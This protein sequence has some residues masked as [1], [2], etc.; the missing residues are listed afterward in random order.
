M[1][2]SAALL[3][4]VAQPPQAPR[5]LVST[6]WL[7][8]NLERAGLVIIQIENQPQRFDEGHI[9]GARF[10]HANAIAVPGE[11]EVGVEMPPVDSIVRLLERAG[12]GDD[13]HIV[14]ASHG[15]LNAAR[16]W[17]TLDWIGHGDHASLLDGGMQ[18]WRA[19]DRPLRSG[20][21]R[22]DAAAGR[23]TARPRANML[24]DADWIRTR[25]DD[26]GI[27]LV[28]ARPDDEYTGADGGM[29]GMTRAGHIPGAHQLYFERLL[30][31]R[32][33][34]VLRPESELRA[35]MAEAGADGTRTVVAYCM[36]GVRASLTYFTARM[37]G[38]D[39][40]FYDGS[41]H[42]WG[43]RDLP[44]VMGNRPR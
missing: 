14:I 31:S 10:I 17:T 43:T 42:D 5:M 30:V 19:E 18:K 25:L 26:P 6:D 11:R 7:A 41:W 3:L 35:L 40:R 13:T 36:I 1:L 37:L 21:E 27:A 4:L 8:D 20:S 34:P 28:D 12:V 23:L 9:P 33:Q 2:I 29:G 22:S 32:E 24:V 44:T 39:V 16:L 38:H 15:I